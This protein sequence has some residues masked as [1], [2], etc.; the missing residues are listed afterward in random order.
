MKRIVFALAAL[1]AAT[2]VA[3]VAQDA[4]EVLEKARQ[5]Y[6]DATGQAA[7]GAIPENGGETTVIVIVEAPGA[8]APQDAYPSARAADRWPL[9][10]N[11]VPGV[12]VPMG[13]VDA[14]LAFGGIGSLVRSLEGIQAS[15]VFS[16]AEGDVEGLQL[17]GVFNIAGGRIEGFQGAGVFNIAGGELEGFQGA[18]VF[19]IAGGRIKG[20]QGAGVFNIAADVEGFQGAGVFNIADRIDGTQ[21][22]GVFNVA[23]KAEGLMVAPINI[24]D[25]LDGVAIGLLNFIGDGVNE[26]G[27]E[28]TP[29]AEIASLVWRNG[30]RAMFSI[31]RLS[32][33]LENLPD[34]WK[35]RPAL[36]IGLGTRLMLGRMSWI[37]LDLSGERVLDSEFGT[38]A[39]AA[40]DSGDSLALWRAFAP[41]PSLGLSA[42]GRFGPFKAWAGARVDFDLP[43]LAVTDERWRDPDLPTWSGD[44]FGLRWTARPR[45][46]FGLAF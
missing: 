37:D 17:S 45:L 33:P 7:S 4:D 11:W 29:S 20:F 21:V 26:L 31:V 22:A 15:S 1:M 19:N 8:E 44:A 43:G 30:T 14:S 32:A 16:L 25:S 35:E 2:S 46:V 38:E 6:L 42:G 12:G 18:G 27:V 10:L 34:A 13:S 28:Y 9:V 40:L 41:Y 36:S 23:G 5:E 39:T 24:A 3:L